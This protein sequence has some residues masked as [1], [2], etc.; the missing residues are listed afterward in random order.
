MIPAIIFRQGLEYRHG[1]GHGIGSYLEVHEGQQAH[2]QLKSGIKL[3]S[4]VIII[5]FGFNH[6]IGKK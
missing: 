2:N 5:M 6:E 1:T 3:P 4:K